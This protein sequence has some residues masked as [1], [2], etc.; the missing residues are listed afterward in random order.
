MPS[1]SHTPIKI[2]SDQTTTENDPSVDS[3]SKF[4][5]PDKFRERKGGKFRIMP[6]KEK[7]ENLRKEIGYY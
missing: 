6:M 5:L 7:V 4:K 2:M 3:A 1:G